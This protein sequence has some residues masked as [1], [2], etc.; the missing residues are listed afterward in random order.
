MADILFFELRR[1]F[2]SRKMYFSIGFGLVLVLGH[3]VF[4]VLPLIKWL[5]SWQGDFFL[6]PHS[7]YGH[8][9]GM[10]SATVW[11]TLLYMLFPFLASIPFSDT[12]FWDFDS[13]YS[14]QILSRT[15]KE[16]YLLS[17]AATVFV[18]GCLL[19]MLI[20]FADFFATSFFLPMVIPEATTNLYGINNQSLFPELFYHQP[21]AYTL[22]YIWLDGILLGAWNCL[23][24][25]SSVLLRDRIQALL[26]PYLFYLFLYFV[27]NW[28]G[29]DRYSLFAILLPFQPEN[30]TSLISVLFYGLCLPMFSFFLY[31]RRRMTS[32][33]I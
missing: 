12:V 29:L 8:W 17:K 22:L 21:F 24:F 19:A 32:D 18:S 11:P 26:S 30:N 2:T 14:T 6:T 13:G 27:F 3:T 5:D 33:A 15:S 9:I 23:I 25:A 7:A 28:L 31:F 1:C 4:S 16:K 10:D 20:L